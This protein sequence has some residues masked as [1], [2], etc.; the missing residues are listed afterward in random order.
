MFDP[1]FL[2]NFIDVT[3]RERVR[4]ELRATAGALANVYGVRADIDTNVRSVRKLDVEPELRDL[5][6]Q[7][8]NDVRPRLERHF[9]IE[10]SCCEELQFLRYLP[11]D[12]FVAHQDGNTPLIRDDSMHRR[13]SAVL[14]LDDAYEG[15]SL[16]FH[17]R[18]PDYDQRQVV[19]ATPGTLVAFRSETT[20]EVTPVTNGERYTIVT[21]YR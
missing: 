1:L 7:K 16:V 19:R 11:G 20:H 9:G 18:Y 5:V 3:T 6:T 15:G 21:W 12:F 4:R 13:I 17:G 14:F 10:V 2:D 8:F